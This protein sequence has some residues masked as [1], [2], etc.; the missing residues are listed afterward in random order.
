[1]PPRV[2]VISAGPI[3]TVMA[4]P[5]IRAYEFARA[6]E[7][8]A[9]VTLGAV[10]AREEQD[11]GAVDHVSFLREEPAGWKPH[12]LAADVI[13]TQPPWPVLAA[14]CRRSGA[15]LI[16]DL[17]DPEP[18]ELLAH[19]E[20]GGN[21]Q[22]GLLGKPLVAKAW[23]TLTLDRVLSGLHEAHHLICA[24]E[25]QRDLWIGT[26]MAERLLRPSLY[27]RDPS[28]RSAIDVAPFGVPAQPPRDTGSG[29]IRA[30]FEAIGPDDEIV[31]W[32]GGLWNWLDAPAA[33]RA[34]G[35]LRERR[36]QA[37]LVFM[38]YSDNV[39][40]RRAHAQAQQ[41]AGEL[42]LLDT[43]VFFNDTWVPYTQRGDWLLDA[44]CAISTHVEHLETRF[45][46]RTRLLDCFWAGLPIVCT[47]GDD[48]AGLVEREDLGAA[49]PGEDPAA[50]AE[51]LER[52][53]HRGRESYAE[54]LARAAAAHAWPR[55]AEPVI[56]FATAGEHTPR[57][58]FHP[59][60]HPDRWVRTQGFRAARHGLNAIGLRD[61]PR[62]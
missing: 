50:L 56:R 23:E 10:E 58:G 27:A 45:A 2:L 25:T 18:L 33:I 9:D 5:A 60:L 12:V 47:R 22:E 17:Y 46:F 59:A 3:G 54:A 57:L 28:L 26:L 29:G 51:A 38:G 37:R 41:V 62:F 8:H 40:G 32:N 15:R 49:V 35:L 4:G 19:G 43:T 39:N 7:P 52:V 48:L 21:R 36:P 31:L 6:L 13:V 34:M 42:G 55:V 1:M 16:Y 20:A 11:P 53:L 24:S 14:W 30:R 44:D 61:W